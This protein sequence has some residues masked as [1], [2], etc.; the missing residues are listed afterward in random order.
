MGD[1]DAATRAPAGADENATS[2]VPGA[3]DIKKDTL[4]KQNVWPTPEIM[5]SGGQTLLGAKR[6]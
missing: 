6:T 4:V 3:D 1:E 5:V 2:L